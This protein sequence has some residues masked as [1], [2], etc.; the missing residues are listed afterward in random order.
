M[1]LGVFF[2]FTIRFKFYLFSLFEISTGMRDLV[3]TFPSQLTEA[4]KIGEEA[5]LKRFDGDIHNVLI[6]GLGGSGIGGYLF[7]SLVRSSMKVP[8]F[9]NQTYDIP[10]WVDSNTLVICCSYSGNTE[11][12]LAALRLVQKTSAEVAVVTSGGKLMDIAKEQGYNYIEIPG[13]RPPR[14]A[15]S[16]SL[17][18]I[19]RL[20]SHYN[21][22]SGFGEQ[23]N[24]V[25][26]FLEK[27]QNGILELLSEEF[28]SKLVEKEI[29][30]YSDDVY[31][32]VLE[33]A[34]QQINEN[35]KA[36]AYFSVA[37]EMTHNEIVGWTRKHDSVAIIA[38]HDKD[39][40][41]RTNHRLDYIQRIVSPFTSSYSVIEPKGSNLVEK[42]YYLIHLFDWI[43]VLIAEKRGVDPV[44][45]DVITA[46]KEKLK[47][48]K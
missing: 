21:L 22:I 44:E 17:P 30:M 11:E 3:Q 1:F 14:S 40:N 43:S 45:V 25:P 24:S 12:T 36:L 28:I 15:L 37:P 10:A 42:F 2:R 41:Y 29:I 5:Q 35:S 23:L 47:D 46:L 6:C 33:R 13:G 34:K 4:L 9:L 19:I 27:E 48:I 31:H 26:S 38:I 8:V 32:P 20:V 39:S 16:Y 18:Q 7:S